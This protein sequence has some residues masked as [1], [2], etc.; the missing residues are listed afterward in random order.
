MKFSCLSFP[1]SCNCN[2][3]RAGLDCFVEK[4][5]PPNLFYLGDGGLCDLRTSPCNV[6]TVYNNNTENS[7]LLRCQLHKLQ[8]YVQHL[9]EMCA[10]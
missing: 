5:T 1:E 2:A 8:V 10:P 6:I 7:P 9:T 3:E 4:A